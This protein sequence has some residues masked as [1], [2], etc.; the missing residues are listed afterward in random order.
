MLPPCPTQAPQLLHDKHPWPPHTNIRQMGRHDG[1]GGT[2]DAWCICVLKAWYVICQLSL[3]PTTAGP[4]IRS[5]SSFY[6][7]IARTT[8]AQFFFSVSSSIFHSSWH[9]PS[10]SFSSSSTGADS[11]VTTPYFSSPKQHAHRM[12]PY[13]GSV[14]VFFI[15]LLRFYY[16]K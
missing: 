5:S 13:F 7:F 8:S 10:L 4:I 15:F 2:R 12:V 16:Y 11:D 6:K 1:Q 9:P 14:E 3:P